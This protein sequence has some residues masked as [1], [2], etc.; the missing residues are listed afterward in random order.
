MHGLLIHLYRSEQGA[1]DRKIS[2][3]KASASHLY[4]DP[5]RDSCSKRMKSSLSIHDLP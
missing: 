4:V 5:W 2:V 3:V 1:V